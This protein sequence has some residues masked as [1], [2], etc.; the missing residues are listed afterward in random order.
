MY[1][2]PPR[3]FRHAH[4]L[5]RALE[6]DQDGPAK[7]RTFSGRQLFFLAPDEGCSHRHRL[8]HPPE[9]ALDPLFRF[10]HVP[11]EPPRTAEPLRP[12]RPSGP[13]L[14]EMPPARGGDEV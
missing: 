8:T 5:D 13:D 7:I 10:H 1:R 14:R 6:F 9:G 2:G 11:H 3:R 4:L 12:L